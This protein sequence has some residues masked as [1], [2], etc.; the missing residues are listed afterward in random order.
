MNNRM[1]FLA[2]ILLL[3]LILGG[4]L[5]LGRSLGVLGGKSAA[6][7]ASLDSFNRIAMAAIGEMEILPGDRAAI[8][9]DASPRDLNRLRI[10]VAD[11]TLHIDYREGWL[12]A[13]G[14]RP[15]PIRYVVT[16]PELRAL[17]L[18]GAATIGVAEVDTER[19]ELGVRGIGSVDLAAVIVDAIDVNFSGGGTVT[20]AGSAADQAVS[21]SGAGA[22]E[23]GE[24]R[25]ETARIRVSGAGSAMV[26]VTEALD[27]DISGLGE[28]SYRGTPRVTQSVT[29]LGGVKQVE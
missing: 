25:S 9:V 10:Y 20:M 6:D 13:L 8:E 26:W 22:Y 14:P 23:A 27:I 16:V 5:A 1:R 21:I 15:Q 12:A 19:F 3:T 11:D 4:S 29:G 18:A 17:D 7:W 2:A 24:L 28:V